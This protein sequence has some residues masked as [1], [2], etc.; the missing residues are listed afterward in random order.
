MRIVLH[1]CTRHWNVVYSRIGA[2]GNGHRYERSSAS[3]AAAGPFCSSSTTALAKRRYGDS[4][5]K[6]LFAPQQQ[7]LLNGRL[8]ACGFPG[9][10]RD[11]P[12]P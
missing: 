11:E 9:W 3:R 6:S 8:R 12:S 2:A 4:S 5:T 10:I 7:R 1:M